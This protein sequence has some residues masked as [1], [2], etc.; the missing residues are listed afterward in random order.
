MPLK[1]ELHCHIEGAAAPELVIRQAQKYG[2]DTSPY[3]QNGSFVWHDFTSFLAAYDFS[4]DLFRTEEDYARL[5]DHYLTS[6]ARDGAI[7]SEI[8]TSPDHA[9]RAGLSPKAYTDALGEGIA[10]A[11]AKTGIEGRMI[12]TGVRNAGVESIEQAARFAARCGHPL[13]TGFGVAGDERMG[14]LEDYVR[15]F[16]IAREAGLGITV[17]AG[18]LMGWE[19][20]EAAL[21]HIRPSRIGHGVR[22]IEN[23]DLVRRIADEGVVLECCPSSNVALKVFD[24]FADHPFPALLAAG[25]KVTLNSD[26]PPYFWTSLKREYDIAAEHFSMNDKALAAVTRTAIEAAFVDRKTKAM[27]LGRLDVKVR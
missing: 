8:F 12:V 6:L 23:P 7:Y 22:A 17:H 25:C 26:D 4:S 21:G 9:G 13:V 20:V 16:E 19:S 2:K 11:K 27:L 5:A 3:I 24:S 10:R 1:A 15:A 18:E 14:D